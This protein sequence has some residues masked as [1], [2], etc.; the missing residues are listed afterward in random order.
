M[1][2]TRILFTLLAILLYAS[3]VAQQRNTHLTIKVSTVEGDI[4]TGQTVSLTQTD[5]AVGYGTLKLNS[6]G[7]CTLNVFAGNHKLELVRDGFNPV[8]YAFNVAD[9]ETEK[10][11]TIQLIEKTR[12]PFAVTAKA[13]RDPFT[14]RRDIDLSWN[15]EKPA[16]FDDF[17]SHEPFAITFGDWTGIDADGE[18]T[19]ALAGTYPNR[20]VMQYAQII[21][22]LTV[23]PTWW[24]EYPILRPYSGQQYVGFIRTNSGNANDDWLI[25]PTITIGTD[26]ILSFKAK[27]ADRYDE[28]FMVFITTKLDNPQ[29]S[30]FTRIDAGNYESVD[31]RGWKTFSY[32]LARYAG[33]Q[34][35]FAI[36]YI[37]NTNLYGAFMLM[38]DDVYVGQPIY[39]EA[40][41]AVAKYARRIAKSPANRFEKFE[42][43]LDGVKKATV[44]DYTCLLTDVSAG[45]HTVGVKAVY[46]Q[47]SSATTEVNVDLPAEG[48]ADVT[49]N[50]TA[51]SKLSPEGLSLNLLDLATANTLTLTVTDGK[52]R[53]P[54]L[55]YGRYEIGVAEGAYEAVRRE[56]TVNADATI[57]LL[58]EDRVIT[59]YNITATTEDDGSVTLNWNQELLFTDSFEDYDDFATGSFGEWLTVDVDKLPVYP[60]ALGSQTNIVS[61]PGSGNANNPVA[62]APMVFNPYKTVPAMLPNDPAIAA[63]TGDKSIIF[64]SPQ[65]AKA[66][67]WLI[68]P[69][70]TIRDGFR[71]SFK[72]KGYTSMYAESL[73]LC[74][75]TDASTNP[76]DFSVMSQVDR[77]TS[78]TWSLYY[79]DLDEY[80]G[81]TVRLAVRYTSNDAF[82]AQVDDVTVGPQDGQGEYVD[83]GNV[84]K[85]EIYLDGEKVGESET[86]EFT[87]SPLSEGDHTVGIKAIYLNGASDM[88]TYAISGK[89]GIT[90]VASVS[91][92]APACL[93]DL[94][95]R[96][97]NA[98][99]A[100]AGIY[101]LRQ[102]T[103]AVK[104]IKK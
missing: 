67:K 84:V 36:R 2:T 100:P 8:E 12:A 92:D 69:P 7:E 15:R 13:S 56:I 29:P 48:Y 28:R 53:I 70:I 9:G 57:D 59:P 103:K 99:E 21:N 81:Q 74:I 62:I 16:F 43:Y 68:T 77:L 97:M 101:I 71:F 75:S 38:I 94:S 41:A 80:A 96:R 87:L 27:A 26:N 1:K 49:F 50:V 60:I 39:E 79:T 95:G 30:D 54:Y 44:E 17:E 58:L 76:A 83:Y 5:Y 11:V 73:E 47:A 104:I 89:S 86:S 24:Y 102:G 3:G 22:P 88:A 64:F 63:P 61:F 10:T 35:K 23:T 98:S 37:S 52:A 32:D 34:V 85:Y 93:F 25:T 46:L 51:D 18:A 4:L 20:G 14:G 19:A 55:P 82:L 45:R 91:S 72:A 65:M 66:D 40:D 33:Q 42:I 31:Y 90:L 6:S 78:E